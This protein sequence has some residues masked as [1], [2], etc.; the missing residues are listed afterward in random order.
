M[1]Q[2]RR[3]P[4]LLLIVTFFLSGFAALLYQVVWQR[5][6]G[7]FS[8]SDVRSVTIV[9]GAFLGG[10]G[11]GSL[12]GAIVADRVGSRR[13]VWIF[14]LCNLGIAAFAVLSRYLYYRLPTI[15]TSPR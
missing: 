10:L 8:G 14:G 11:V 4:A 7:L 5:L 2:T 13:A 15:S 12:V 1:N 9:T 3:V 6:L